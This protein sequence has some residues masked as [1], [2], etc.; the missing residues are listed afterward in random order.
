MAFAGGVED[1]VHPA[2]FCQ[3]FAGGEEVAHVFLFEHGDGV[4]DD[5][6]GGGGSGGLCGAAQ[7]VVRAPG[8]LSG[9]ELLG[10]G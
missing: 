8:C 7:G 1:D 5:E 10:S 4:A 2:L 9:F 6:E 3:G